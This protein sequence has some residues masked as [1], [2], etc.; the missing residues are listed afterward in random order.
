[1]NIKFS[2]ATLPPLFARRGLS[3][4]E[5]DESCLFKKILERRVFYARSHYF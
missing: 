2:E 3:F 5:E 4:V 1:M